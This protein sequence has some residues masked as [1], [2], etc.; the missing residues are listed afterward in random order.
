M[1]DHHAVSGSSGRE[2]GAVLVM[3]LFVIVILSIA[4]IA[5]S[6]IAST[7]TAISASDVRFEGAFYAAE[8][9]M[10]M[11]IEQLSENIGTSTA[12]IPVTAIGTGYTFRSG[13]LADTAPQPLVFLGESHR[14]GYNAAEGTIYSPAGFV[15]YQYRVN[16]T[17]SGPRNARREVETRAEFGPVAN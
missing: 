5:L 17:G 3:A 13:R 11:G 12:A 6:G 9:G 7:D 14:N 8:S 15:F 4:A 10:S 16:A 2:R 1:N